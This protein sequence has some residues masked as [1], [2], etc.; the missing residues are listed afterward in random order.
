MTKNNSLTILLQ[1]PNIQFIGKDHKKIRFKIPLNFSTDEV[2][3]SPRNQ[4]AERGWQSYLP[5]LQERIAVVVVPYNLYANKNVCE[6]IYSYFSAQL[7]A[8]TT[9]LIPDLYC[10]TAYAIKARQKYGLFRLIQPQHDHFYVHRVVV[11]QDSMKFEYSQRFDWGDESGI[12]VIPGLSKLMLDN[13]RLDEIFNNEYNQIESKEY[14]YRI[15]YDSEITYNDIHQYYEQRVIAFRKS[16][17]KLNPLAEEATTF[18]VGSFA[19][20]ILF[21]HYF[22]IKGV[23]FVN[24]AGFETLLEKNLSTIYAPDIKN[25]KVYLKVYSGNDNIESIQLSSTVKEKGLFQFRLF[26]NKYDSTAI[27]LSLTVGTQIINYNISPDCWEVLK[28]V[29]ILHNGLLSWRKVGVSYNIDLCDNLVINWYNE[30][31]KVFAEITGKI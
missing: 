24:E 17:A 19:K 29:P 14:C 20:N 12:E 3:T 22:D 28:C 27:K 9:L 25:R 6:A 7:N 5:I 11:S 30:H 21:R 13:A 18:I 4:A 2:T 31:G 10:I 26:E 15:A 1:P 16:M 23:E 8:K